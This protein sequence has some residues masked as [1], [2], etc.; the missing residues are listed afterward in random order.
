MTALPEAG[1][2]MGVESGHFRGT[3]TVGEYSIEAD[4][5]HLVGLAAFVMGTSY[6][7]V[8]VSSFAE[9]PLRV[10]SGVQLV[11]DSLEEASY[12]G[13]SASTK[14]RAEAWFIQRFATAFY[15]SSNGAG[16]ALGLVEHWEQNALPQVLALV[17]VEA[18][19]FTHIERAAAYG[20]DG[21]PI[22]QARETR[23]A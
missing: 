16:C 2:E 7:D 15:S 3:L 8:Q 4:D 5:G 10:H 22:E 9:L 13:P 17:P 6:V 11:N 19:C 12:G 20:E 18:Q 23:E 1:K 14:E 21:A